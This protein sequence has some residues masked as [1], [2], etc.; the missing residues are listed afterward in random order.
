MAAVL[1]AGPMV[2][3]LMVVGMAIPAAA[4]STGVAALTAAV[5]TAVPVAAVLAAEDVP[6]PAAVGVV[7]AVAVVSTAAALKGVAAD[8]LPAVPL[9][10]LHQLAPR[11]GAVA[12]VEQPSLPIIRHVPL[13][14]G[15]Q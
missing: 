3:V 8:T 15:D 14:Q 13:H 6:T 7:P 5:F 9:V 4:N 2:A 10:V 12:P 1:T 11:R